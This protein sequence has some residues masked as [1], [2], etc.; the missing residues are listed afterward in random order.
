MTV[1]SFFTS[2]GGELLYNFC[3]LVSCIVVIYMLFYEWR[4][5]GTRENQYLLYAFAVM[6]VNLVFIN[7]TLAQEVFWGTIRSYFWYP[8]ITWNLRALSLIFITGAFIY[9]VARKIS[10]LKKYISYNIIILAFSFCVI[11]PLWLNEFFEIHDYNTFWGAYYYNTWYCII[12]VVAIIY[13][14]FYAS[15]IYHDVLLRSF[16]GILFL[17]YVFQLWHILYPQGYF[18]DYVIILERTLPLLASFVLVLT[19]YRSIVSSLVETNKKLYAIRQQLDLTNQGLER[20]VLERTK[21]LTEANKELLRF[22]E[23][24]ENILESLTDGILAVD[25]KGKVLALNR[26]IKGN[27]NVKN[28]EVLGKEMVFVFPPPEGV[29]WV[30]LIQK[31]IKTGK[32]IRLNKLHFTLPQLEREIVVNLIGQPLKDKELNKIGVVFTL[33]FI[34]EKV[35]LEGEIKRAERLVYLG[36]VAAGVAHEIRNPLNSISINLQLLRRALLKDE[37]GNSSLIKLIK[38]V[39]GEISRLDRFVNEFIQFGKPRKIK[40]QKKDINQVVD[41]IFSLIEEQASLTRVT[42][43][44]ELDERIPL[45]ALDEAQIKQVF[46]NISINS[47]QAMPSGGTLCFKTHLVSHNGTPSEVKIN[48]AD[49]GKGMSEDEQKKIFEPFYSNKEEGTGLGLA[50]VHQIIEEHSGTIGLQSKL[51]VGTT[52]TITLPVLRYDI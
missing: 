10:W 23:F 50:I 11:T 26:A 42:L 21:E 39:D 3:Y 33:E 29:N 2:R 43:H 28:R 5:S 31:I 25:S 18:I 32:E 51:G 6:S 49:K 47:L 44:K 40:L 48:I 46:L 38:V 22:K 15:D 36:K 12:L 13:L 16:L 4:R 37:S 35:K 45:V 34:T 24:H 7:M 41:N 14:H 8:L 17:G 52:F 19:I 27:L 20:K 30:E 1:L 9:P